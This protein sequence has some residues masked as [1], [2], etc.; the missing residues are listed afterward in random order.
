[1]K[2]IFKYL[3]DYRKTLVGVL[4]LA[5]I[6][7]VFSLLDPQIFRLLVD[8]YAA[9]VNELSKA[10]FFSGS[11]LLLLGFVSVA[12]ISR[13]AKNFQDYYVNVITHRLG[14]K[15]Y[16]ESVHHSLFLPYKYLLIK[17][18]ERFCRR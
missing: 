12:L 9:R 1:M 8:N 18:P 14:T 4:F 10:E 7:Q 5:T 2:F 15:L 17:A 11:G 16:A 13:I 3:K 6:N